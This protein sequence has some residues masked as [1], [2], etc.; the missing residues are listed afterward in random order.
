MVDS[1]LA[2][3]LLLLVIYDN[4]ATGPECMYAFEGLVIDIQIPSTCSNKKTCVPTDILKFDY[5]KVQ[6][7]KSGE[8][9]L[10]RKAHVMEQLSCYQWC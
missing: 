10:R 9:N 4:M 2:S 8:A 1:Q 7:E 6:E 5:P 3:V